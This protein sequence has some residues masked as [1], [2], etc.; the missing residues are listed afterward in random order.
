MVKH[1]I[2]GFIGVILFVG[3]SQHLTADDRY[4]NDKLRSGRCEPA[5]AEVAFDKED[6]KLDKKSGNYVQTRTLRVGTEFTPTEL[7]AANGDDSHP[8]SK[9]KK[10][11]MMDI[12]QLHNTLQTDADGN[13]DPEDLVRGHDFLA[14]EAKEWLEGHNGRYCFAYDRSSLWFNSRDLAVKITGGPRSLFKPILVAS[15]GI[16]LVIYAVLPLFIGGR[17]VDERRRRSTGL[18]DSMRCESPSKDD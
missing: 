15:V 10:R 4:G 7:L 8:G 13:P 2:S 18:D 5:I 14:K 6:V 1:R 12:K 17:D 9:L 16:G 11:K 3:A